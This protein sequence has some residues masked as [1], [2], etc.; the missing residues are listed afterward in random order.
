M[1]QVRKIPGFDNYCID[2]HGNVY[3]AKGKHIKPWAHTGRKNSQYHRVTLR[4]NGK[5]SNPRVHR[6]VAL[7]FI[8]NPEN[9]SE[10]HHID[11]NTF[12]NELKNL[13]WVCGK[14]NKKL[15]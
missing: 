9:L 13:E 7:T 5:K 15:G 6:L 3:N 8:P 11:G 2:E 4:Q 12:N 14:E 10:V 1:S